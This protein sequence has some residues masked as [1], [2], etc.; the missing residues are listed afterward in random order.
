MGVR[1]LTP[2]LYEFG[3]PNYFE[4]AQ[5]IDQY[6]TSLEDYDTWSFFLDFHDL[7]VS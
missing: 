5:D 4:Q 1:I 7:R 2:N 6:S 3:K